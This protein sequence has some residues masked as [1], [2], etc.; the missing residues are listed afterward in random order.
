MVPRHC[1]HLQ[2]HLNHHNNSEAGI[3]AAPNHASARTDTTSRATYKITTTGN[4]LKELGSL[5]EAV[6]CYKQAISLSPQHQHAFNNLGNA[7]KDQVVPS[8]YTYTSPYSS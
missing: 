1:H 5:E 3:A 2:P 8:V 6:G 7:M 4:A